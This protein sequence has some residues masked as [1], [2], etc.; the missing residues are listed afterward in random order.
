MPDLLNVIIYGSCVLSILTRFSLI[1][2]K[3]SACAC[4]VFS[5]VYMV[6]QI[7]ENVV[8]SVFKCVISMFEKCFLMF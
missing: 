7:V 8:F 3:S 1:R 5:I 4:I 2:V 6:S